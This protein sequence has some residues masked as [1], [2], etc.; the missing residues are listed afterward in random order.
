MGGRG[1][2]ARENQESGEFCQSKEEF[3]QYQSHTQMKLSMKQKQN[4]G[5]REQTGDCQGQGG[6]RGLDWEFGVNR[7]T[8]LYIEWINKVLLYSIKNYIQYPVI[9]HKGKEYEIECIRMYN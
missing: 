8:L 1:I 5:H 2:K 3:Q 4:Q 6:G 7:C 9:N